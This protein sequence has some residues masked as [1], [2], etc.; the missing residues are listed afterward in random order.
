[1]K[2]LRRS[3]LII[4]GLWAVA[5]WR[6]HASASGALMPLRIEDAL[7]ALTLAGRSPI[8]LSPDGRWVAYTLEDPKRRKSTGD[9]RYFYYSRTGA[10]LE[11][12]GCDIWLTS[13]ETGESRNLT[14]GRGTSWDPVWSPDGRLLAFYSD[15]SGIAHLWVWER[16]SQTLRQ[17]SDAIVRPFFNFEVPRWSPDGNAIIFKALPEDL[18]IETAAALLA[19]SS[20]SA[21]DDTAAKIA[22]GE[23]TVRLYRAAPPQTGAPKTVDDQSDIEVPPFSNRYLSGVTLVD[24]RTGKMRRLIRRTKPLGY[25]FS[26]DGTTIAVT[27]IRGMLKNTQQILYNLSVVSL[28]TGQ[29]S[30]IASDIRMD[31]GISV[32]WSPDGARLA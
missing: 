26:P 32:S 31:Y 5:A 6:A 17:V 28:A 14:G 27:T 25:W 15:R 11:A 18:T 9:L 8:D 16:A 23:P 20:T 3:L 19:G 12:A 22:R 24:V 1:M 30:V 4:F 7:G 29:T 21:D 13:T 2:R 10:F